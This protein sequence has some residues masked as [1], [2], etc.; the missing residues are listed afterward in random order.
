[1]EYYVVL[2]RKEILSPATT[3]MDSE[4]ILV[5]EMSQSQKSKYCMIPL[6]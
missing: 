5:S 3:W 1:M 4:D 6:R 2:K